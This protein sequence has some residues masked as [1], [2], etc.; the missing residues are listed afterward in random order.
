MAG[1]D[2]V[3]VGGS[4]VPAGG[5]NPIEPA[6]AG[7]PIVVGPHTENFAE[8]VAEFVADEAIVI[9]ADADAAAARIGELLADTARRAELGRR[10]AACV[11]GRT[12]AAAR[13]AAEIVGL[14][15]AGSA[16]SASS[17]VKSLNR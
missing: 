5:H 12:G 14:V 11:A 9:A 4:L 17:A 3:F 13:L 7:K 10:A 2:V 6:R 16:L 8:V 1:A 15:C